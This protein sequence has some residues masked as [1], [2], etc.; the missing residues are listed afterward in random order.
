MIGVLLG[1]MNVKGDNKSQVLAAMISMLEDSS[2]T[3]TRLHPVTPFSLYLAIKQLLQKQ[4]FELK[5]AEFLE[6]CRLQSSRLA[7]ATGYCEQVVDRVR[8]CDAVVLQHEPE[9]WHAPYKLYDPKHP[10]MALHMLE[11]HVM[12]GIGTEDEEVIDA[13]YDQVYQWRNNMRA[14]QS[15]LNDKRALKSE[16]REIR[17]E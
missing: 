17:S 5:P 12:Y 7:S 2:D 13:F 3:I 4:V 11:Q 15:W 16:I 14:L 6:A 8:R 1:A 10:A 9:Q